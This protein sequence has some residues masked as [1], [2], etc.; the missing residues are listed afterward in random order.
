M[1]GKKWKKLTYKIHK[2]VH[3]WRVEYS[4]KISIKTIPKKWIDTYLAGAENLDQLCGRRKKTARQNPIAPAGQAAAGHG[5]PFERLLARRLTQKAKEGAAQ[6]SGQRAARDGP[7]HRRQRQSPAAAVRRGAAPPA[8]APRA[9][10]PLPLRRVAARWARP[11]AGAR[12]LGQRR[13]ERPEQVAAGLD[14]GAQPAAQAP[15]L[16]HRQLLQ[17]KDRS[18]IK[19]ISCLLLLFYCLLELVLRYATWEFELKFRIEYFIKPQQNI[20]I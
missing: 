15:P 1:M 14:G 4:I 19:R 12:P 20:Y 9:A 3:P 17:V 6:A 18:C 2:S 13:G 7:R 11:A 16:Q 8:P 5:R 10:P